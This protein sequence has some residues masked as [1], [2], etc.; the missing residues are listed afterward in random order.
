MFLILQTLTTSA[1]DCDCK[2]VIPEECKVPCS[3]IAMTYVFE[4]ASRKEIKTLLK[5][6]KK[7]LRFVMK[8]RR[9]KRREPIPVASSP[10]EEF[11]DA[12]KKLATLI[13]S[14]D[15]MAIEYL[16]TNQNYQRN[17]FDTL[18]RSLLIAKDPN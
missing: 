16:A 12:E 18:M 6:D 14:L 7:T 11:I 17:R 9:R 3:A 13:D 4:K 2:V 10:S 8:Y 15:P 1:Q 5:V